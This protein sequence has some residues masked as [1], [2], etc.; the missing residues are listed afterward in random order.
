VVFFR[1]DDDAGGKVEMGDPA[2]GRENWSAR[3]IGVLWHGEGLRL[4]R[5]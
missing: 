5:R 2:I 3:D 1:F 4:V